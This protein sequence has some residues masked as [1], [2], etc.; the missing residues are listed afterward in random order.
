MSTLGPYRA[1]YR[2]NTMSRGSILSLAVAALAACSTTAPADGPLHECTYDEWDVAYAVGYRVPPVDAGLL[3]AVTDEE[4]MPPTVVSPDDGGRVDC[5]M[6]VALPGPGGESTCAEAGFDVPSQGVLTALRVQ[7][8][9]AAPYATCVVPR[10]LGPDID[11]L[12]SCSHS[13]KAGWC[14]VSGVA[15]QGC[16]QTIVVT[17]ATIVPG[18]AY[19]FECAKGC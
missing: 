8:P 14:S 5:I 3:M 2:K 17:N 6:L 4:C 11:A 15:G 19:A 9:D 16:A 7:R 13:S 12:G 1:P 18:A 10:L